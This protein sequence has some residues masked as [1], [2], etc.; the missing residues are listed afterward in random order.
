MIKILFTILLYLITSTAYCQTTDLQKVRIPLFDGGVNSQDFFDK[1]ADN[2]GTQVENLLINNRGQAKSRHGQALYSADVGSTPFN[3]IGSFYLDSTTSYLL[4]ASGTS[5][6]RNNGSTD[7]TKI[8]TS[9]MG[10]GYDT[11]FIQANNLVFAFNGNA[12]TS[13]WNGS[14][15]NSGG[16]WPTSPPVIT[17]AAWL[18]NY[19]FGAGNPLHTDWVYVS[20]NLDPTSFPTSTVIK[21]NSGDGTS[22]KRIEPYRTGEVIIYKERSIWDLDINNVDTS[23]TPQPT[24]QWTITAIS[25][26]IGTPAPRSVVSLGNDQ[27]FLSSE[28]FA[29]RSLIRSQFD[30]T[31]VEMKSK[32]IQDIF[33]GSG[34]RIINKTQISKAAAVLYNNKYILAVPT[35]SSSVNDFVVVYD[36]ITNSWFTITG[37]YPKDWLVYDN[38][39]YYVDANDGRILQCF[40]GTTGDFG[41]VSSS[42]SGPTVGINSQYSSRGVDFGY[43]ENYKAL[44][45]IS[46]EFYPTGDFNANIAINVDNSGWQD[47]GT[48][49]L[50]GNALTLPFTLPATLSGDGFAIATLQLQKYGEFKRIQVRVTTDDLDSYMYLQ[51]INIYAKIKPWRREP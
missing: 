17:T 42:A 27:W 47:V 43:P 7:W 12:N 36:F 49:N 40:T 8:S 37:W 32:N 11:G 39:L 23:C 46:V 41:T 51:A 45:S 6:Y 30:K 25:R 21:V 28:P 16:S 34:T 4:M 31:F 19:L 15:W 29:V 1:I 50:S 10:S 38:N 5:V 9:S 18:N 20:T 22:I 13:W 2:E 14:V 33:D 3:G 26:D 44:D 48:I 35:G 24:C